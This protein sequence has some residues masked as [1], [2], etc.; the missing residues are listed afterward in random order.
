M[1]KIIAV[2]TGEIKASKKDTIL[3]SSAIGSCVVIAAYD[4]ANKVG[5]L[6]HVMVPGTSPKARTSQK[7]RY[8]ADAIEEMISKMLSLGVKKDDIQVCLVGAGNVLQREDDT[9]CQ[10]IIDSVIELLNKQNIEIKARA[11]GGTERKSVSLDVEKGTVYYT[12]GDRAEKLLW[13]AG[14]REAK[15]Y[16]RVISDA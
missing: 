1:K 11:I 15:N 5:A 16:V 14:E 3:K 7:T 8:A 12:E 2:Y 10:E 13:E 9:I 4:A 6:A